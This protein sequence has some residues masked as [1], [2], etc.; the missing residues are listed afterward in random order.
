MTLASDEIAKLDRQL[1]KKGEDVVLRRY[2]GMGLARVAT[3]T[4]VRATVREYRPTEFI[5]GVIQGDV[6]VVMTPTGL[7]A[8][9]QVGEFVVFGGREHRIEAAPVVRMDG[10]VVRMDIQARG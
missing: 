9:P 5:G 8:L 10:V 6:K 1:A 3:N 7:T 2:S 4:T